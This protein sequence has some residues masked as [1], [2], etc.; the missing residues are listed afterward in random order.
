MLDLVASVDV[1]PA[2]RMLDGIADRLERPRAVLG[3]MGEELVEHE[4]ELFAT[5]GRGEWPALDPMTAAAKGS[6]RI[7]VDSGQLMADLTSTGAVQVEDDSVEVST[8]H[9]A[10]R[11][12]RSGTG[13]MP[14]RDPVLEPDHGELERWADVLVR[15]VVDG[16]R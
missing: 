4:E 3:R 12:L 10:A 9:P 14:Q 1:G 16:T 8:S 15:A 7:L 13:K 2:H 6:G 5:G 11:F